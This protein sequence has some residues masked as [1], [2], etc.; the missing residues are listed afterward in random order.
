MKIK[1]LAFFGIMAAIMGVAG[2]ARADTTTVIASQ[3]YV[4]AKDALDEKTANKET[5]T[6]AASTNKESTTVYPSMKTLKDAYDTLH[7]EI[8]NVD[9][10]D[11]LDGL[12]LTAV[13][14]SGKPIVSVSQA[15]GQVAASAGTIT[16]AGIADS[17]IATSISATGLTSDEKLATESAVRGAINE[18]DNATATGSGT[19]VKN[20]TQTNGVITAEMG[21]IADADVASNAAIATS[22]I[23][24]TEAHTSA[25]ES[26]ITSAKV[27]DY[28]GTKTTVNAAT[29]AN[30]VATSTANANLLKGTGL[31]K[32]V[33]H[34]KGN[35]AGKY[36]AGVDNSEIANTGIKNEA[37]SEAA[38]EAWNATLTAKEG[39]DYLTT[40]AAVERRVQ[41]GVKDA[42]T[43]AGTNVSGTYATKD[44]DNLTD[45]GKANVSAKGTYSSSIDYGTGTVGK[46]IKDNAAAIATNTTNIET[47]ATNIATLNGDVST[48]GSV[49]KSINENAVTGVFDDDETY[50]DGTIG[51]AIKDKQDTLTF[52]ATP[53]AGST[54]PVTSGGVKTALDDKVAKNANITA[55]SSNSIVQYDAK[56]L[57]TGGTAAGALATKNTITY[58]TDTDSK[59]SNVNA[60]ND[61][62]NAYK[63]CTTNS[64]CTLTMIWDGTKSVYEWTNMDTESTNAVL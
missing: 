51:A 58:A 41:E 37:V 63:N 16:T 28:E 36:T 60:S 10:S 29:D 47:N 26:G 15:N 40:L 46:A 42:V 25:L 27:S 52:D 54:N 49:L 32:A 4:D 35:G 13:S 64:P 23:A 39:D 38:K 7:T 33:A 43:Q 14:E 12:D 5:A 21:T 44:L 50:A 48:A 24:F 3:A 55:S 34:L 6:Y 19:V 57:V 18:L 56:G 17:A 45:T 9:L 53:T 2:T 30:V 22:K 61:A 31:Q 11:T 59:L 62:E 20:V 1:N 8:T